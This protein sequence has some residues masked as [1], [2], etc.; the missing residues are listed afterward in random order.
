M[1]LLDFFH[2]IDFTAWLTIK[3]ACNS[4]VFLSPD[5]SQTKISNRT[6]S[7]WRKYSQK[8]TKPYWLIYLYIK[9]LFYILNHYIE[10][11]NLFIK[12]RNVKFYWNFI[13]LSMNKILNEVKTKRNYSH[14]CRRLLHFLG[15]NCFTLFLYIII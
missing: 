1:K 14:R 12:V 13:L 6:K 10:S 4:F 5:D 11:F 3:L 2:L 7:H 15:S 8:R 9:Y